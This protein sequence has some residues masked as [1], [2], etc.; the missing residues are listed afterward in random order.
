M[1][2][3]HQIIFNYNELLNEIY[4]EE[5]LDCLRGLGYINVINNKDIESRY[6][7]V[8]RR[9]SNEFPK[10][11]DFD[12]N[13]DDLL[14]SSDEI[15]YFT[16]QLFLYRPYLNDPITEGFEYSDFFIYPNNEN[17]EAKRFNIFKDIVF[18]KL[19]NFWDR[20]GDLIASFFPGLLNE[21]S[22]Y[23]STIIDRVPKEYRGIDG[24]LWL[25]DFK[26]NKFK[27]LN[28]KR[29]DIVHYNSS[30]T[31]EK[32]EHL[33]KFEDKEEVL[34]WKEDR[35]SLADYCRDHIYLTLEGVKYTLDFLEEVD[36]ELF[37]K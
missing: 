35:Y 10:N 7:D 24:F 3:R 2:K 22:I 26:A 20:L 14:F 18:E 6:F 28:N 8:T 32:Y 29:R 36:E 37:G 1:D 27:D 11:F 30:S 33:E 9:C 5:K 21:N 13:I 19:Y 23:F 25:E 17:A 34:K 16:A 31:K 12:K 15:L 4:K